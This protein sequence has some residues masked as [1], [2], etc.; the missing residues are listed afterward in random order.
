VPRFLRRCASRALLFLSRDTLTQDGEAALLKIPCSPARL[1]PFPIPG[2]A[3]DA[4]PVHGFFVGT[5]N[6]EEARPR[7]SC[8]SAEAEPFF[9]FFFQRPTLHSSFAA[10]PTPK[11]QQHGNNDETR[12]SGGGT[13]TP[14]G[15]AGALAGPENTG[16]HKPIHPQHQSRAAQF[17][18]CR[19]H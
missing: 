4:V 2:R 13:E 10:M 11:R 17:V 5:T 9:F 6:R 19:T 14:E 8:S 3:P 12:D 18:S 16:N 7:I 15:T 1:E